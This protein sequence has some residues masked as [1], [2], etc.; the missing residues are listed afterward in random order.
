MPGQHGGSANFGPPPAIDRSLKQKSATGA[1]VADSS[2]LRDPRK[3]Q[4]RLDQVC[5]ARVCTRQS[6]ARPCWASRHIGMRQSLDAGRSMRRPRRGRGVDKTGRSTGEARHV[7]LYQWVHDC[8][9]YQSLS[10]GARALLVEFMGLYNG[11]NNGQIYM[12]V[13][14]AAQRLDC[15]KNTA[16]KLIRELIDRGFLRVNVVGAFNMKSAARRGSATTYILTEH[17]V[18]AENGPGSRE[19]MRWRPPAE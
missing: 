10:M 7:R 9:A 2:I 19:F 17:P 15:G 1:T 6:R 4:S 12:S 16:H 18:G 3:G 13:R 5:T 11:Y 8:P 14:H